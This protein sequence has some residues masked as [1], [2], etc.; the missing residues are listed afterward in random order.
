MFSPYR[1]TSLLCSQKKIKHK[2]KTIYSVFFDISH[3]EYKEYDVWAN[4][5]LRTLK[6]K[7]RIYSMHL[8]IRSISFVKV[9]EED[10][11]TSLLL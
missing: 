8:D 11:L 5:Q 6:S 3:E 4:A 1:T 2:R 7:K 10:M 9:I